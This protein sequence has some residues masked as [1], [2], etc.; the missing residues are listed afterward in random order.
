MAMRRLLALARRAPT[1]VF[2][3]TGVG[4]FEDAA[5]LRWNERIHACD[6][7]RRASVLVVAG[8]IRPEDRQA[9]ARVHDQ[10]PHPRTT[11]WHQPQVR[12]A[13]EE[14]NQ[15]HSLVSDAYG[16]VLADPST[17]K[18]DVLPDQP[19]A[20]WRGRGDH[21]QGGEGMMGGVPYGRPM[22]MTAD[23]RDGLA[24]DAL[25]FT[26]GPFAPMLPSGLVLAVSVQG[27][28]IQQ[29]R[30][31]RPPFSRRHDSSLAVLHDDERNPADHA[32]DLSRLCLRFLAPILDLIGFGPQ[33]ERAF[34]TSKAPDDALLLRIEQL[35]KVLRLSPGLPLATRRVGVIPSGCLDAL[36][37]SQESDELF[38]LEHRLMSLLAKARMLAD[39]AAS[40]TAPVS[41]DVRDVFPEAL[42]SLALESVL[43]EILVGKEWREAVMTLAALPLDLLQ[44]Q[45]S[46]VRP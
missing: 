27:D 38:D 15:L 25:R 26:V 37:L 6:T 44:P 20:P 32:R 18:P 16:A 13:G 33:A 41:R 29:A 19:P 1:P 43:P 24:L 39:D 42:D 31:E 7:P 30:V 12:P 3:V 45:G 2:I 34:L 4:G 14:P 23:D 5:E 35:A 9:V 22:A 28:V 17:S 11:V 36:G 21:G 8:Q 46:R 10:M 40:S